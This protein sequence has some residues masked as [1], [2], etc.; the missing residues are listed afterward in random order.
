MQ[1]LP[2]A[3]VPYFKTI[4]PY[5]QHY[6]YW[7]VF[8]GVMLEDFGVPAPGETVLIAGALFAGTGNLKVQ[9]VAIFGLLG[10]VTG[11]NLGYAIGYYGG[12]KLIVKYGRYIFLNEKRV[13]K[14]EAFFARHGGKVVTIARFIE[15]LRQFNGIVAGA[16]KMHWWR[17]LFFNI[18]GAALWVGTWVTVAYFFGA[19]LNS[20]YKGFKHFENYIFIGVGSLLLF[21]IGYRLIKRISTSKEN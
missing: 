1:T 15:G 16:S 13:R 8:I 18:M 4:E 9:W 19:Q 11:D 2:P 7:A 20:I 17:F 14:V 5:L 12:R 21:F 10:A 6:G 3:L